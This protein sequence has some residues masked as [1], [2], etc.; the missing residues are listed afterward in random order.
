MK[1]QIL[2]LIFS[3]LLTGVLSTASACPSVSL[4]ATN[5]S[6]NSGFDGSVTITVTGPDGPFDIMWSM[7][8]T[9]STIS[10]VSSGSSQYVSGLSAGVFS[11]Y[12]VDQLGCTSLQSI[13]VYEPTAVQA[14][15]AVT[16]VSCNGTSTGSINLS[17]QGGTSPYTYNWNSGS[18][19]TEDLNGISAGN[20]NVVVTDNHGCNSSTYSMTVSQPAQALQG[21][22]I[23]TNVSCNTGADGAIN[24][25]TWGGTAPYTYSWNSG[26]YSS[27]DISDLMAGSYTLLVT[28]SKGCQLS[29]TVSITQ[30]TALVSS[31]SAVDVDCY[32]QATGSVNLTPSGGVAPY[33]FQWANSSYTLGTTEDLS[34]VVAEDYSV[35][36]TDNNGCTATNSIT[37]S[38]PTELITSLTSTNVSCFGGADGT[39]DLSVSG[40]TP[41]YTYSWSNSST[42]V[43]T[44]QDLSNL[45]AE[46]YSVTVTDA[47]GCTALNNVTITQPSSPVELS[48]SQTNVLCHGN[49]TGAIDITV[50][51]GTPDY[52]YS[53]S[54]STT[55]E[56]ASNLIA[57]SYSVVVSDLNGCTASQSFTIT[58]P[59][60][61]LDYSAVI[62]DVLCYGDSTGSANLTVSGGTTP[63]TY[64]WIN[65]QYTL[66]TTTEDLYQYPANQY[67]FTVVDANSCLLSD[68][69]IIG[70][71][72]EITWTLTPT[73]VLCYGES[74]GSIDLTVNGG[75][76]PYTYSWSNGTLSEDLLNQPAGVYTVQM[77]DANGCTF[78]DSTEI[79]EPIAPLSSTHHLTEPTCYNAEDGEIYYVVEGGTQP[80]S[81][82]WSSGQTTASIFDLESGAYQMT[83]TD[84]HGCQLINSYFLDQPDDISIT[85]VVT[86]VNCFGEF[87]GAIDVTVVGGTEPYEYAWANSEYEMSVD[88]QDISGYK[89]DLYTV[90]VT[91]SNACSKTQSFFIDEPTAIEVDYVTHDVSCYQ[92]T[93]GGADLTISGGTPAYQVSW[94]NGDDTESVTAYPAGVYTFTVLDDHLCEYV[95]SLEINEPDLIVFNEEISPVS[96]E[97]QMDGQIELSPTGGYGSYTYM[98]SNNEVTED[99]EDLLGGYYSVTL[100]DL[101]GCQ[102][103]T[104]LFVPTLDIECL[105]I[106]TA[107][108]PNADGYNDVWQILNI[109]L[110]PEATVQV[111][112]KWGRLVYETTSGYNDPWDG[113]YNGEEL[114]AATYYYIIIIQEDIHPYTGP[115]TIVR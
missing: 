57:G 41:V 101:V 97:D 43:N 89:T 79:I 110:Y 12:V 56:D 11:V 50:T 33:T 72:E 6:C 36:I 83:V 85:G 16:D 22:Y 98:W 82:Q 91:D 15:Y 45:P 61:A 112:N 1:K 53:W 37:V 86:D 115:I 75:T 49:N 68:T 23:Q 26:T 38:E 47:H 24:F 59:A 51:G 35:T 81:Y 95:D 44:T 80:Y 76:T 7:G 62:S 46:N 14:T 20:Y 108:T 87:N 55:N 73:E 90:T 100:T 32:A 5:V 29:N 42:V 9:S 99:I 30:P 70:Q 3:A 48:Y 27:E 69:I 107:Y 113:T 84:D 34:N 19:S 96:C 114:P 25:S 2:K 74:T 88:S 102:K 71:P 66:S 92:G 8:S 105:E 28:D 103:D 18:Y 93:D 13:T 54:N 67:V 109:E 94:E 21:S 77:F 64:S 106:P 39:I 40:G 78:I 31:I 104:T 17:P 4:S 60:N 58:Q 111:F 63:Y 52:T 65:A 10:S